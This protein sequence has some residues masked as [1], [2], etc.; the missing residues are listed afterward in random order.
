[1]ARSAGSM[2]D[3]LVETTGGGTLNIGCMLESDTDTLEIKFRKL[4]E[5]A[6][7]EGDIQSA[8]ELDDA[9]KQLDHVPICEEDDEVPAQSFK[10]I[11]KGTEYWKNSR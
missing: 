6:I 3:R 4:K 5:R 8:D 1:M 10:D 7:S 9:I 11:L 2:L